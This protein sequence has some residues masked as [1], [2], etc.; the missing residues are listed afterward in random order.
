M[1]L[2]PNQNNEQSFTV[3][4]KAS[5]WGKSISEAIAGSV[6]KSDCE[7][8][9]KFLHFCLLM[10]QISKKK[11]LA[12]FLTAIYITVDRTHLECFVFSDAL[13]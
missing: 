6:F 2:C 3:F 9:S 4:V 8:I 7:K 12:Y 10:F 5:N 13:G 1:T 11:L